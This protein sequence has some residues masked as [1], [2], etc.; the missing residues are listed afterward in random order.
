M[1]A[2]VTNTPEILIL[3]FIVITFIQSAIDKIIDWKGNLSWLTSHFKGTVFRDIVPNL[4]GVLV[5][6]ELVSGTVCALGIIK[7][8]WD[9]DTL[10]AFYG[11]VLSA[12]SMLMLL[13]GQRLAKD[14]DGARTIA[15]YFMPVAF[16]LFLLQQ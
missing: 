6:M 13:L 3:L 7:I 12:I 4:L 16:L 8:L 14:Y 11:A 1:K 2:F 10:I 15:I 9:G 5:F